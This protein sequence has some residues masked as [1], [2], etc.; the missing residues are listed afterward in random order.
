MT[1]SFKNIEDSIKNFFEN[2]ISYSSVVKLLA[3]LSNELSNSIRANLYITDKN[4]IAPNIFHVTVKEDNSIGQDILEKWTKFAYTF[5]NEIISENAYKVNG[6]VKINIIQ[7]A[8]LETRFK[9]TSNFSALHSGRTI[10]LQNEEE[11]EVRGY[12]TAHLFFIEGNHFDLLQDQTSIGRDEKNNIVLDNLRISRFHARIY[13]E[14]D[15]YRIIDNNSTLGTYVNGNKIRSHTLK[16]GDVI[17]MGDVSA[18]FSIDQDNSDNRNI[19]TKQL[20]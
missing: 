5:I 9:I 8:D 4:R 6:P 15:I 10:S 17:R 1:P 3:D 19:M 11:S 18:V 14:N 13:K 12:S 2:R 16:N 7:T 20:G